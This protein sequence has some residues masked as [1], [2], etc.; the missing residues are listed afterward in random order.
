MST[1]DLQT[2]CWEEMMYFESILAEDFCV[3][4]EDLDDIN[5]NV[6]L[7]KNKYYN[8]DEARKYLEEKYE[9]FTEWLIENSVEIEDTFKFCV[10]SKLISESS[11]FTINEFLFSDEEN[12]VIEKIYE[13]EINRIKN[14][15]VRECIKYVSLESVLFL[16]LK[17]ILNKHINYDLT[18]HLHDDM[19][20]EY[21]AEIFE[22]EICS[23]DNFK[24]N[25]NNYSWNSSDSVV[26]NNKEFNFMFGEL[27]KDIQKFYFSRHF[28]FS[29]SN[30]ENIYSGIDPYKNKIKDFIR[31]VLIGGLENVIEIIKTPSESYFLIREDSNNFLLEDYSFIAKNEVTYL[32][33]KDNKFS[34]QNNF[35][36]NIS[37]S[38][39]LK[40]LLNFEKIAICYNSG[41]LL[42]FVQE[43]V[44]KEYIILKP[45]LFPDGIPKNLKLG[46]NIE[47]R[48]YEDINNSKSLK[49]TK[50]NIWSSQYFFN[51]H[52]KGRHINNFED[53]FFN[54]SITYFSHSFINL[55]NKDFEKFGLNFYKFQSKQNSNIFPGRIILNPKKEYSH[56]TQ[57]EPTRLA[58]EIQD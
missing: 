24:N 50:A 2:L 58:F 40:G 17:E 10:E 3:Y 42:D 45:D 31:D 39:S 53:E 26:E 38:F 21:I 56:F 23:L 14:I 37:I 35:Y 6:I 48:Y 34:I 5:K 1:S 43:A 22:K 54:N 33:L 27:V 47:A 9:K 49:I 55:K 52:N 16:V 51:N 18:V 20:P 44:S 28:S 19:Y 57:D 13:T 11:E 46:K 7:D 25:I 36:Q 41:L 30:L 15:F 8:L 32:M 12:K 29:K 4:E